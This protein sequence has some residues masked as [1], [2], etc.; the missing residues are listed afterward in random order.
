[1]EVAF[2]HVAEALA[3][4]GGVSRRFELR[5]EAGGVRVVDDYAHHP[6]EI[7][8]TLAAALQLGGRRLVLFQPHRY[9]RTVALAEEFGTA[10]GDADGVWVLDVYGAGERPIEGV[11]GRTIVESARRHGAKHVVY[12]PDAA[13]AVAAVAGEARPGDTVLTLGAGDVWKLGDTLLTR[14]GGARVGVG[15]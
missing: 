3:G 4:F 9:T 12:A 1:M 13:A 7:R 15:G 6:T 5:G 10:F 14:L 8:A 2:A 11:S